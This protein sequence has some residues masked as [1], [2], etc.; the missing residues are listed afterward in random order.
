M[1]V[2]VCICTYRRPELLRRLLD[3][4]AR[5][6]TGG[7]FTFSAVIADNDRLE[8]ARPVADAIAAAGALP[9]VYCVEPRQNIALA[10]TAA[11]AHAQGEFAAFIDDDEFPAS[12]WLSALFETCTAAGAQGVLGPVRPHFEQT[13][14]P[15]VPRSGLYD[16]PEH[17]TGFV[18]SWRECRTGNVLFWRDILPADGPAFSPDFP[19][20]GEDQDFFRRMTARGHRFVW[21]NEAV[22]YETVPP[23]RWDKRVMMRRALLRGRN[24]L[25]HTRGL[26][27][28]RSL[29]VSLVAVPLYT[30]ALP[31]LAL[32]GMHLFMRYLVRLC[33]HLG[34]L[35]AAVGF[36]P[37]RER[38]G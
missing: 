2:T 11:L 5:Q 13:P 3:E 24:T 35:L 34:R 25:K 7:R 27:W 36:N 38:A 12:G 37:V 8:S 26:A 1:H 15:W 17:P 6:Q 19:N 21:C 22:A 10:R 9:V 14:P 20:G 4:L 31:F 29:L 18:M 16:R 23:I 28:A 30:L 32:A 33:D